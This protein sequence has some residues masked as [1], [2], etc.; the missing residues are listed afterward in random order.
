MIGRTVGR[1]TRCSHS[2]SAILCRSEYRLGD[3]EAIPEEQPRGVVEVE[4]DNATTI[5]V[6]RSRI[7]QRDTI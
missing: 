1:S 5:S 2:G 4:R 3:D 7:A 6:S